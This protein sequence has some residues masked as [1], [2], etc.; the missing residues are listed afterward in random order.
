MPAPIHKQR[1]ALLRAPLGR[2]TTTGDASRVLQARSQQLKI[3]PNAWSVALESIRHLEQQAALRALLVSTTTISLRPHCAESAYQEGLAAWSLRCLAME[4][5]LMGR[6]ELRAHT[7]ALAV[8]SAPRGSTM[9]IVIQ[10]HHAFYV[11]QVASAVPCARWSASSAARAS[12][13]SGARLRAQQ[14]GCHLL[15]STAHRSWL[16]VPRCLVA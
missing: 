16:H 14:R 8:P 1:A 15:R 3:P 10:R 9:M 12:A 2:G 13:L 5:V 11:R 7:V 4:L 6:T